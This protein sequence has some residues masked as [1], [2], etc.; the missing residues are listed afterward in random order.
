MEFDAL[1]D[2][3]RAIRLKGAVFF[4]VEARAPWLAE[5]PAGHILGRAIMP[6]VDHVID[7]HVVTRG[8][9]WAAPADRLDEP[10]H[11]RAG[12]VV[13]FA[14]GDPHVLASSPDLRSIPPTR[15]PDPA[16]LKDRFPVRVTIGGDGPG[17]DTHLVCGFLACD[18]RPF[19]PLLG[20]LPQVLHMRAG[21]SQTWVARFAEFATS[22]TSAQ[23][24]GGASMLAKIGEIMFIDI[25]RHHVENLPPDGDRSWLAGLRDRQV[26]RAFA[27]LHEAPAENWSLDEL[28]RRSGL[29]R[30]TLADRFARYVGMPPMQYLKNWRMQVASS[31]LIETDAPV[32]QIAGRVGYDSEEAF[33]RAFKRVVGV[34]PS[35]WRDGRRIGPVAATPEPSEVAEG[36]GFEPTVQV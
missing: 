11:L 18:A 6:G 16:Q 30:S 2:I 24:A 8:E 13:A 27:L 31:M 19:N 10:L 28:A 26:G 7:Y 12:D 35:H 20:A 3:F 21:D 33:S 36:M 25:V 23:R 4:D 14:H 15:R 22:E 32:G 29:S 5:A 9:C 34:A 1:S 17:I